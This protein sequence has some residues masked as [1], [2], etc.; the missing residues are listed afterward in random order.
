MSNALL[1]A[2][3]YGRFVT[4]ALF[5]GLVT[6]L[7]C[8]AAP[9]RAG[10]RHTSGVERGSCLQIDGYFR[11]ISDGLSSPRSLFARVRRRDRASWLQD[12]RPGS[13]KRQNH[14]NGEAP[15]PRSRVLGWFPGVDRGVSAARLQA[16]REA[17]RALAIRT[18]IPTFSFLSGRLG[19]RSGPCRSPG[20]RI[21]VSG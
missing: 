17:G 1:R 19:A 10:L 20:R 18:H 5:T 7:T 3:C 4:G 2:P 21:A 16:R 6:R 12:A 15:G 14:T 13:Q 9:R 11:P 8:A